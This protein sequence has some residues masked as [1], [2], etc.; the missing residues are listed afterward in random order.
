MRM[1]EDPWR[2]WGRN[3]DC[4]WIPAEWLEKDKIYVIATE[5]DPQLKPKR[6]VVV[7]PETHLR[8]LQLRDERAFRPRLTDTE[9][10]TV[11]AYLAEIK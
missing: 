10:A 8:L 5:I 7:H 11:I 9:L 1:F 4:G 2:T 3:Y 6:S